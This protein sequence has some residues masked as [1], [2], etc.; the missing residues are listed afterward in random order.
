MLPLTLKKKA[1]HHLKNG[2]KIDKED[3]EILTWC[4]FN[5]HRSHGSIY[6]VNKRFGYLHRIILSRKL[7][8]ALNDN[9]FTDHVNKNGLD[10]RRANL[11]PCTNSQNLFNRGKQKNST[12]GS[13]GVYYC[14]QTGKWSAEVIHQKK[15]HWLGRFVDKK[16]AIKSRQTYARRLRGEFYFNE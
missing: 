2:L 1:D 16:E 6:L 14:K 13:A 10:N 15:K 12:S 4:S 7:G 5:I 3:L 11:R 8:R 9:D